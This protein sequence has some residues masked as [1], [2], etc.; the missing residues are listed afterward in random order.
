MAHGRVSCVWAVVQEGRAKT[1]V[2]PG[3]SLL[4]APD[5]EAVR[6]AVENCNGA[7]GILD[8]GHGLAGI[9][10]IID[11]RA[12]HPSPLCFPAI[13]QGAKLGVAQ[14][15]LDQW[16]RRARRPPFRPDAV[17]QGAGTTVHWFTS[18]VRPAK[19]LPPV[20]QR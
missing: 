9:L 3:V 11:E 5:F 1:G 12:R 16:I 20:K 2:I 15:V 6:P 10:P 7:R 18:Y 13:R 19:V 4:Q 14:V 8:L 17:R